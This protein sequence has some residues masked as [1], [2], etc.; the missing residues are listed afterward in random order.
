MAALGIS[1]DAIHTF[2]AVLKVLVEVGYPPY[3][4][5]QGIGQ[6]GWVTQGGS[7]YHT[8]PLL[9]PGLAVLGI[10]EVAVDAFTSA[11]QRVVALVAGADLPSPSPVANSGSFAVLLLL[12]PRFAWGVAGDVDLTPIW[13]E[14][15]QVKG[16]TEGLATLNQTL[17]RGIPYCQR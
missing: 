2:A 8:V 5:P 7:G 6:G 16:I 11:M 10:S 1:K 15:Y 13:E 3:P 12:H 14:V 4:P 9:S 17:L